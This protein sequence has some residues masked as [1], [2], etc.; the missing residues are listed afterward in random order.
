[1]NK[2]LHSAKHFA[3]SSGKLLME[4]FGDRQQLEFKGPTNFL[5]QLDI[6]SQNNLKKLLLQ[7]PDHGFI[8]EEEE[9]IKPNAE[10]VWVVDPLDGTTNYSRGY[11]LFCVSVAL[12]HKGETVL[13]IVHNPILMETF[14]AIK[15]DGAN[16][17][18]EAITTSNTSILAESLLASGFP[19]DAWTNPNNNGEQWKNLLK[20][21]VS[22]RSD[23][24]AALDLCHVALGRIDGYWEL[25][26]EQ[27]DI[28]AG[29]LIVQEAG[30]KVSKINGGPFSK[31][32]RSIIATNGLIHEELLTEINL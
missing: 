29:A 28:A 2:Y 21:V 27:W 23:G 24:S 5:T 9:C 25:D 15:G 16:L 20:K 12:L 31:N 10:W 32:S 13:G 3:E 17:N 30:G 4:K 14:S 6:K 22:L 1:M 7:Y 26:L 11:P 19:Y 8:A 18:G